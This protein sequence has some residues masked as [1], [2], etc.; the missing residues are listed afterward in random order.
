[1]DY[2]GPKACQ[3]TEA[4]GAQERPDAMVAISA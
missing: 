3:F 4:T 1:M 2:R